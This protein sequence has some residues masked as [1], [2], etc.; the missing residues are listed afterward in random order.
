MREVT[1][2]A[3]KRNPSKDTGYRKTFYIRK[4]LWARLMNHMEERKKVA[5]EISLSGEV[6]R[7]LEKYLPAVK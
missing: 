4:N 1:K 6:N 2:A 7:A 3:K 5:V